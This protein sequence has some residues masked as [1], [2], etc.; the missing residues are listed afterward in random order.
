MTNR[1]KTNVERMSPFIALIYG[2]YFLTTGTSLAA[3]VP[4]N[5][6][7]L[8][9]LLTQYRVIDQTITDAALVSFHR[10]CWHLTQ[11]LVSLALS[12]EKLSSSERQQIT[13]ALANEQTLIKEITY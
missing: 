8:F 9:N 10:H 6:L 7:D 3:A 13:H 5:D 11:E 1:E 2:K 12:D 4:S